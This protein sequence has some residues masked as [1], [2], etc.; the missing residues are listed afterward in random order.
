MQC[1][2]CHAISLYH[3]MFLCIILGARVERYMDCLPATP[4][5]SLNVFLCIILGA[6]VE[7]YMECPSCH[8]M[9]FLGEW[10]TPKDLQSNPTRQCD[11]CQKPVDTSFLIQ[12]KEKRTGDKMRMYIKNTNRRI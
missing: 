8:A 9:S 6:R 3:F 11:S 1:H 10:Q 2:S 7:R 4:Y 5:L 12:P